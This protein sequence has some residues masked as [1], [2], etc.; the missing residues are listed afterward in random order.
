MASSRH[1]LSNKH[2]HTHMDMHTKAEH[3]IAVHN[4]VVN[5][6]LFDDICICQTP[7]QLLLTELQIDWNGEDSKQMK[8][9]ARPSWVLLLFLMSTVQ[10]L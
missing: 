7:A 8:H 2:T 5:L 1:D 10:Y 4:V 6:L 9:S 3:C